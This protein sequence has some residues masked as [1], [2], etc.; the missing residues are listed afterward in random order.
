MLS[1]FFHTLRGD[2]PSSAGEGLE[3]SLQSKRHA[4]EQTSVNYIGERMP[5]QDSMKVRDEVQ[6]ACN[7]SQTSEEDLSVRHCRAGRKIF[8]VTRVTDDCVGGDGAQQKRGGCQ[9]RRADHNVSRCGELPRI[10]CDLDF[11]SVGCQLRS[12]LAQPLEI[13][14]AEQHALHAGRKT[15]GAA[16]TDISGCADDEQGRSPEVS[17]LLQAQ[18]A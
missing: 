13:A 12:Q 14:S 1:H 7:L 6:C 9:A 5:I 17:P 2:E 3:A 11:H 8:G 18:L 4:F 10:G 15:T 16:G